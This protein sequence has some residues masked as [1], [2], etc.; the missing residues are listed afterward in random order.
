MGRASC[1]RPNRSHAAFTATM[2]PWA[3][4]TAI[5]AAKAPNAARIHV[6]GASDGC[7]DS[8]MGPDGDL[9]GVPQDGVSIRTGMT[10]M[11]HSH[12]HRASWCTDHPPR[13]REVMDRRVTRQAWP[14]LH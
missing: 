11:A 6:S 2:V 7:S 12:D 10:T 5:W 3:S 9:V 13:D 1:A 14:V 4:R 8:G